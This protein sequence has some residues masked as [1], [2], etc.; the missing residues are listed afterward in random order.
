M[1]ISIVNLICLCY[2]AAVEPSLVFP[3]ITNEEQ[4]QLF[5][6]YRELIEKEEATLKDFR[7]SKI[8]LT[9]V[10]ALPKKDTN[11]FS[12]D[13]G[14]S[15]LKIAHMRIVYPKKDT[16]K[17]R[18]EKLD[19]A[20]FKY[21]NNGDLKTESWNDWTAKCVKRFITRMDM[22]R[23]LVPTSAVLTFS[24]KLNHESLTK[25]SFE[26]CTKDWHFSDSS[27]HNEDVL[28]DLN[29]SLAKILG[30]NSIRATCVLNDVIATYMTGMT[31]DL[32]NPISIII[33]TGTN[34]GFKIDDN[35]VERIV[36][37]EWASFD[38]KDIG[39]DDI[40]AKFLTTEA[41]DKLFPFEVLTA[42]LRLEK[43]VREKLRSIGKY[44]E[45]ELATL[46]LKTMRAY[47]RNYKELQNDADTVIKSFKRRAYRL[48]APLILAINNGASKVSIIAN[49]SVIAQDY[50]QKLL[51]EEVQKFIKSMDPESNPDVKFIFDVDASLK[52][53]IYANE[54]FLIT[55]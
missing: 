49:G 3:E 39:M 44:T 28:G 50:D 22:E 27:L 47:T 5:D 19:D 9:I 43:I 20:I 12:I 48:M 52:G 6:S 23:R 54:R 18:F 16:E 55:E 42:G 15:S 10:N 21:S 26:A 30:P 33:G 13:L 34:A 2:T 32:T 14:G 45:E 11:Y 8:D 51:V 40:S 29:T 17:L 41:G 31:Y 46:D 1:K 38:I 53:T 35:G 25:A 4:K 7:D 37:S 36:N 24:Y